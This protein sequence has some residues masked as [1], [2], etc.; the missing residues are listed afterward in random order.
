LGFQQR[1]LVEGWQSL[2]TDPS[3]FSAHRFLAD[4]YAARPRQEIAR[5]SE[6]LQSQLLQPLN[7]TP[8]QPRLGESNLFLISAGG[9]ESLSFQ[10]F[11]PLFNR[12]RIAFQG[13]GLLGENDTHGGEGIVSG[14]YKRLSFSGGYTHFD[15]DGWRDN[16]DQTDKIANIFAQYELNYKTNIQTEYRY[17]DTESGDLQLR[18]FEDEFQ[19]NL[20]EDRERHSI[21][22]GFRHAFAPGSDL[23]GN[24]Q[25][26]NEDFSLRDEDPD[27]NFTFPIFNFDLKSDD[28]EN[29]GGELSY[30]LRS[31]YLNLVGG[32]GYFDID[33][34]DEVTIF[35]EFPAPLPPLIL[36][37]FD[38][39]NDVKHTNLYAYSYIKPLEN[40]TLTI[41][42]SYDDFNPDDD[43]AIKDKNQFNPKFGITWNPLPNT[44]LRTAAFRVLKRTLVSDQTLEPT[45]V[46]G[47]NQ[48]FDEIGATDYWVYGGAFDQKFT[49]VFLG[50]EF[51]HRDLDVPFRLTG[52]TPNLTTVAWDEQIFRS[53]LFWTPHKWLALNAEYIY[54]DFDRDE[55]FNLNAKTVETHY[56]P[57]GINFFH[58]SGLSAS[59]KGTYVDQEGSFNRLDAPAGVTENGQDDFWLFDASISYR[60]PKR[61]GFLTVGASNLTDE[62][63]EYFDTDRDNPRI[64]PDRFFFVK[65]TLALP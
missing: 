30:L 51:T 55:N 37:Q 24:F 4:S 63:F 18:F 23:I 25:Y 61:Y 45:Q 38:A 13:S 56:L 21:R 53:Y 8:I 57:L 17:R 27:P 40:L 64:Q 29:Y 28:V 42:A 36:D 50:A 59:V 14:I 47:F 5:V 6:L 31:K 41:G 20:E 65:V 22:L 15:T 39:D 54:E 52:P 35:L 10:E 44:T 11:N 62:E 9:P 58:P 49:N 34:M 16:A 43:D 33:S 48:F 2:N 1:A 60:F 3:N 32:A 7:I 26:A 12:N 46:A 19:P